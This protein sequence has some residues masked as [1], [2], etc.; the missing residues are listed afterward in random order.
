M[1]TE[2][3]RIRYFSQTLLPLRAKVTDETQLFYNGMLMGLPQLLNAKQEELK[4]QK[5]YLLAHKQYWIA[6]SELER[7]TGFAHERGKRR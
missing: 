7:A 5:E 2:R 6:Y 4:T 3:E 1:V